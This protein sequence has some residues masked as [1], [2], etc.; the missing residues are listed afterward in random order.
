M[1]KKIFSKKNQ[2][3]NSI[4]GLSP[5]ITQ[6]I[7][8]FLGSR[9]LP[10]MP[11]A[12]QKAFELSVN[13]DADARDF[14]EVIQADEGLSARILKIANS[15]YFDRGR[16]SETIEQ[17]VFVIGLAE[18]RDL[19]NATTLNDLFPLKHPL[20]EQ[21]WGNAI[22]TAI[23]AKILSQRVAPDKTGAAFM[24]GMMHDIGKLLLLQRATGDYEKVFQIVKD[25]GRPFH[26]A[27]TEFFVFTHCEIGQLVAKQ[28][29]FSDD[30]LA[31]IRC[32]H[33]SIEHDNPEDSELAL[34]RLIH[35]A[36]LISHT[37]AI[38]H[39]IGMGS[40]KENCEATLRDVWHKTGIPE[41][42]RETLLQRI[43][44]TYDYEVDLYLQ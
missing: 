28:W 6:S 27:E 15:V 7:Q 40:F 32:H 43:K 16:K 38:G 31:V 13:P 35:I 2:P 19:L 23:A 3:N 4:P 5:A 34:P 8:S 12:A 22:G 14:V 41:A 42:E 33:D 26:E 10:S 9:G 17:S 30:M 39:R 24:C 11:R 44:K 21:F 25:T 36:D 20:R 29:N 18:L 1:F 37:L